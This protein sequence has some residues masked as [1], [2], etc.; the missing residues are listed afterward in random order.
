MKV[1]K[2]SPKGQFTLPVEYR[3]Q[4]K[5]DQYLIEV[6]GSTIILK[7]VK[8]EVIEDET[9]D[10]GRLSEKSFEFWNNKKDDVY[11]EFYK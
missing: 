11:E 3:K 6:K 8:I 4:L 1:I 2:L 7:P 9:E 10:F 5:V